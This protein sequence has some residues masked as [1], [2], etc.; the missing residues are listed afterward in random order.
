MYRSYEGMY[1]TYKGWCREALTNQGGTAMTFTPRPCRVRV[2]FVS[3]FRHFQEGADK[4][5]AQVERSIEV[6]P[7]FNEQH[8]THRVASYTLERM[9]LQTGAVFGPVTLAYE[10]WG[11][12]N[13]ARDN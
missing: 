10:T 4:M 5:V 1:N 6:R 9:S 8:S 13:T 7:S 11:T 2:F 3:N 12:L